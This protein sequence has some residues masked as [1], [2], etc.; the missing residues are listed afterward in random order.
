MYYGRFNIKKGNFRKNTC[1]EYNLHEK[2]Q[3]AL[4]PPFVKNPEPES[5]KKCNF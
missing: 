2:Q 5:V 3:N 4:K 1:R